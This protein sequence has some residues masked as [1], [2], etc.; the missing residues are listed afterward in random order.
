MTGTGPSHLLEQIAETLSGGKWGPR[1]FP[2]DPMGIYYA[3]TPR[4]PHRLRVFWHWI[5]CDL[6]SS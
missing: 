4:D 3:K 5:F 1:M 6:E 2:R